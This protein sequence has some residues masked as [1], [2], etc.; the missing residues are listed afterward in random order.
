MKRIPGWVLGFLSRPPPRHPSLADSNISEVT[1]LSHSLCVFV[2][3]SNTRHY[4]SSGIWFY[5]DEAV[6]FEFLGWGSGRFQFH[7]HYS[8]LLL[9][10]YLYVNLIFVEWELGVKCLSHLMEWGTKTLCS[11]RS[12]TLPFSLFVTMTNTMSMHSLPANSPN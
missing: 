10:T 5:F 12:S 1:H 9:L 8:S 3:I 2:G 4:T 11:S 7:N 6:G